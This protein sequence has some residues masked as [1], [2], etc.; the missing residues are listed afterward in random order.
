[1]NSKMVKNKAAVPA[2]QEEE[3]AEIEKLR[4]RARA[5]RLSAAHELAARMKVL[6]DGS[7]T[8]IRFNKRERSQHSILIGSFTTLGVTG[9]LQTFSRIGLVSWLV[10]VLLGGIDTLRTIHHLAAIVFGIQA[11]YHVG[12]IIYLWFVKREYGSMWPSGDDIKGAMGMLKFNLN[13]A[14][15]RPLFDRF[16]FEEKVEYW[17]L[18]WG[19]AIMGIT[20]VFQWFPLF[21]TSIMPGVAI[22]IARTIHAWEAILAVLSILTWHLYHTVIKESNQSIFTGVMSEEEMQEL[23]TLEYRRILA[24]VDYIQ[25]YSIQRQKEGRNNISVAASHEEVELGATD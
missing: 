14:K 22:P 9:L 11:L 7:R 23:H 8:F 25:K 4:A 21:V 1:M 16:S 10:N 19:T 15:E 17:A 2:L 5:H 6:P 12:E 13:K 18:L 24:A 20:G 3:A